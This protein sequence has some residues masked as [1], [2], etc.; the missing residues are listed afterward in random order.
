MGIP[1]VLSK[2]LDQ[3]D[4]S[5]LSESEAI[6][7]AFGSML[8]F[9]Q[10]HLLDHKLLPTMRYISQTAGKSEESVQATAVA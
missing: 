4:G 5:L 6:V 1:K 3:E 8:Y 9:L 10:D 2:V 7:R